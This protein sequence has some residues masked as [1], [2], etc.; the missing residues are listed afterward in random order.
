[1]LRGFITLLVLVLA[2]V[3]PGFCQCRLEAMLFAPAPEGCDE[4]P[5]P[6]DDHDDCDCPQLKQDCLASTGPELPTTSI[7][8]V[9]G[10]E[11]VMVFSTALRETPADSFCSP[12]PSASPLYLALRAL[13]I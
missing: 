5:S 10:I 9:A 8:A 2:A 6:E 3:P 12:R 11:T 1:M 7:Q 4:L 13:R